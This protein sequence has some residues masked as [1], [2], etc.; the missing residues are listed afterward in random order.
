MPKSLAPPSRTQGL[1]GSLILVLLLAIALG[2]LWRQGRYDPLSWGRPTLKGSQAVLPP[3]QDLDALATP[4]LEPLGPAER[5][6]A[7]T[8]SDKIDGKAELYL[9]AGFQGLSCRRY[10]LPGQPNAWFEAFVF[11]MG[12]ARA[13]FAVFSVQRRN[14][15]QALDLAPVAYET[16]SSLYMLQGR[17]YLEII[18]A[19]EDQSLGQ[20]MRD[21]AKAWL[22]SAPAAESGP[23]ELELFPAQGL[24]RQ[25]LS[26]LASDVFGCAGLEQ[27]FVGT[28]DV[29]GQEG[30]AFLAKRASGQEAQDQVKLYA[31]FLAGAGGHEV[32]AADLPA[33][34]HLFEIMGTYELVYSQGAF[35]AGVHGAE[36]Q[37]VALELGR[38]LQE[39]LQGV[40][41]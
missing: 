37:A 29:N 11:D 30:T 9:S 40:K 8:L 34:G 21:W 35:L 10:H 22:A 7:Q 6:D 1:V 24:D 33:G 16:A 23:G 41:P 25:S 38:R 39:R 14:Q 2:I 15:G 3:A 32:Q 20:G 26:L 12:Q 27:V 13:A 17:Y 31:Q 19:G 36:T 28:Y 4:G 5:F 18:A